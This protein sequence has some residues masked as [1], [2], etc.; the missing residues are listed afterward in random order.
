M[1]YEAFN[2]LE[3]IPKLLSKIDELNLKVELFAPKL[4]TKKGVMQFL[5]KSEKTIYN[6]ISNGVFKENIHFYKDNGKIVFV[7]SAIIDFKKSYL[8]K[9]GR[10]AEENAKI[11]RLRDEIL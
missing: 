6:Y 5:N 8:E 11:Q 2:N 10:F 7:E 9:S 4:N 3:L 1:N